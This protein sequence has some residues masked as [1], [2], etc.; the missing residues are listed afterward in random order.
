MNAAEYI[1]SGMP[2]LYAAGAL[3]PAEMQEA[4]RLAAAHPE[5]SAAIEEAKQVLED[6]ANLHAIEPDGQVRER[7]FTAL[8]AQSSSAENGKVLP[9]GSD[10][11]S[12]RTGLWRFAAIAASLLLILSVTM[13]YAFW[14]EKNAAEKEVNRYSNDSRI[15]KQKLAETDEKLRSAQH[16]LEFLRNPM[17]QTVTLNTTDTAHPMKAMVHWDMQSKMVAIDPMTLPETKNNEMYVLWAVIDG[18]AV[19]KGAFVVK[20]KTEIVMMSE[21]PQAEAFAISLE[22]KPDVPQHEGPVYVLGKPV[23]ANP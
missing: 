23:Y 16:E 14:K 12:G 15:N 10:E 4:E 1:T 20:G 21:I 11:K 17:T 7:I 22:T 19:N 6:Y 5:I 8:N 2:E 18:K 3:S 13:N 9:L